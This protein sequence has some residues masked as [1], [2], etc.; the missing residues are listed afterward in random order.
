MLEIN[1]CGRLVGISHPPLVIAEI[2][3]NHDGD[4]RKAKQMIDDANASDAEC[5]KFQSHII[6]DEMV[7]N[8][9]IP[10]NATE[11]IWSIMK[12]CA[13]S[14]DEEIELKNYTEELGMIYLNTPF[15][16]AAADRLQKMNVCAFKIGSGECNNFPLVEHIAKFKKPVIMSTGMNSIESIKKSVEIFRK[17][18]T[19]YALLH[20]TSLYPTP[21]S[22]VRLGALSD[23]KSAF[24]DAILGLSDHSFGNYTCFASIPLGATILEKHFTSDKT[25]SGPDI[26]ISLVPTELQDLIIGSK[27]IFQSLGGRKDVL[28][29]EKTTSKFAYASVVAICDIKKDERFTTNNIWVKRP[30]TGKIRAL[31]FNKII[32]KKAKCDI[33]KNTQLTWDM[34]E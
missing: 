13:F 3:I 19:P 33:H 17:Y 10:E 22:K 24:P 28:E 31:E 26:P 2:G 8:N 14:E 30:G 11:S 34:I 6:D 15:S 23:L 32:N 20:V 16:R 1:L 21:Y 9:V 4:F 29:E 27:A 7:E 25:W 5:V 12:R 18:Q